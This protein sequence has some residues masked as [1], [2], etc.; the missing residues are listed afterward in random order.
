VWFKAVL[1]PPEAKIE[2]VNSFQPGKYLALATPGRRPQAQN[3][4]RKSE[5]IHSDC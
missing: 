4:H 2:F 1:Y 5:D 3:G